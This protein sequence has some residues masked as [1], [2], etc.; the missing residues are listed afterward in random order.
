MENTILAK[1]VCF[2]EDLKPEF[3][4][5]A[6]QIVKNAKALAKSLQ[7]EGVSIIT[8][9]TDNHLLLINVK[10]RF[11]VTGL[12]AQKLLE[13]ANITT[14][15]NAIPG[16]TE[17]PAYTSGLRLGTPAMT[18][19]GYKEAYFDLVGKLIAEVLKNPNDSNVIESVKEKVHILNSR[20]PLP[21][22]D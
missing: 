16:D 13:S 22:E 8:G 10:E 18:T 12:E 15:K 1:A 4:E 2:G 5:Y 3:T 6:R 21:Y 17:K 14:N 19:R 20:Y 11:H 9:G 7:N